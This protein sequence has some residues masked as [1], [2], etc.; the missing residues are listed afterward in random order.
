MPRHTVTLKLQDG[1]DRDALREAVLGMRDEIAELRALHVR[2][3]AG[4][5]RGDYRVL[6][7][8]ELEDDEALRACLKHPA[9]RRV[10]AYSSASRCRRRRGCAA[11]L[12][13]PPGPRM[14]IPREARGRAGTSS[15]TDSRRWKMGVISRLSLDGKV[16]IGARREHTRERHGAYD[17][18]DARPDPPRREGHSRQRA[19][20]TF[21]SEQTAHRS[22]SK[23][24]VMNARIPIGRLGDPEDIAA[25]ALSPASAASS[26]ITCVSLPVDRRAPLT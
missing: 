20:R 17:R 9:H 16:A 6:V 5:G 13:I 7:V 10:T 4:L 12:S 14:P 23:A 15:S 11:A 22:E 8:A 2:F 18:D 21:P 25:T 3:D 1:A 24:K 26:Y 19:P